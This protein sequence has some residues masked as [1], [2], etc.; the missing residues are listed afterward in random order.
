MMAPL[1]VESGKSK[2]SLSL[3]TYEA[4]IRIVMSDSAT[5]FT[6]G[7]QLVPGPRGD[8]ALGYEKKKLSCGR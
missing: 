5:D 1:W 7:S 4:P 6:G 2:S 8:M 3:A